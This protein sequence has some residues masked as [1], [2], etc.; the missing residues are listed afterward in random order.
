M[1]YGTITTLDTLAATDATIAD[2]GEDR[3]FGAVDAYLRAHNNIVREMMAGGLVET[4]TDRQRRYGGNST[5]VMQELDQFGMPDAQKITAGETIGVPLRRFGDTLQW[6]RSAFEVMTGREMA[7]QVSA[8]TAADLVL[9]QREMKRALFY[10]SNVDNFVDR[11]VDHVQLDI[12]RLINADSSAMPIG[13]QG[14]SFDGATHT[15]YIGEA[16]YT[17][18]F[19]EDALETVLEH[20]GSGQAMIYINRAQ[21]AT[22]RT[23]T[24]PE[25][26]PYLDARLVAAT[27]ATSARGTLDSVNLYDRAI[28]I[29]AGAEV[30]VKP[31][32]PEN[33]VLVW[34]R[35]GDAQAPLLFR[36]RRPGSGSLKLVFEDENHPLRARS[37]ESEFG[38]AVWNRVGASVLYIANAT[39]ADPSL[40]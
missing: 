16:S 33:Y 13:P 4:T 12:K 15:H 5:V 18:D 32:I 26:V 7:A 8:I 1:A 22:T 39:Y 2:I 36:E 38:V 14:Q 24:A 3:A 17:D 34:I 6:T 28:G 9:R 29:F 35:G 10:S 20:H 25:F 31:W 11:L 23:F 30:W 27:D 40:T 21:E 37:Y 19:L